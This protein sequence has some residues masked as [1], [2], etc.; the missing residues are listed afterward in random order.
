MTKQKID[1][2]NTIIYKIV[3]KDITVKDVYVGHTTN[4]TKR[5]WNHKSDCSCITS[6]KYNFYVYDII[7]LNGGWDNWDMIMVHRQSCI[8]THEAHTI[9]RHYVEI[10]GATLNAR[11]PGRGTQERYEINIEAISEYQRLYREANSEILKERKKIYTEEN[12]Q[13]L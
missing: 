6:K 4:F 7:R 9:E 2:S 3:C 12:K 13:T 1:Y 10:L 5:K 8:D 11:T